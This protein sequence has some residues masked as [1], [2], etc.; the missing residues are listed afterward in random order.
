MKC[1]SPSILAADFAQL[2]TAVQLIDQA[3]AQY[4]HIDVMDGHFVPSISFGM[5]VIRS[6]RPC[7][8]RIFDVHLMVEEPIGY[9][10]E[11]A[12][13]G[14]D[15]ITVHAEA[16]THL[17][18]TISKIKEQ[19][20][21]AGVALN[22]ATDLSVL[23]YILPKLDMVLLMSVNPGYGGQT[24]IPYV[25]DKICDLKQRIEHKKLKIDIE[26]DGGITSHN[27]TEIVQAGANVIVA[28]S[29]VFRGNVM[30][31]VTELL[32]LMGK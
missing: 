15:I 10:Q 18:R 30:E 20:I 2:G 1:L 12:E 11:I 4:V 25:T 22:P 27:V 9:I 16:C 8:E 5:P 28:G 14:A 29:A 32:E 21:L 24:Y 7:T 19:G 31:N 6:I 17:D 13:C 23:E 26:V 3:G